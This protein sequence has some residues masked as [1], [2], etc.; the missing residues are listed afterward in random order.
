MTLEDFYRRIHAAMTMYIKG[1][2]PEK[3]DEKFP[4][5]LYQTDEEIREELTGCHLVFKT[6]KSKQDCTFVFDNDDGELTIT[7]LPFD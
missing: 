1:I 3:H 7:N 5:E 6:D 2:K 4:A